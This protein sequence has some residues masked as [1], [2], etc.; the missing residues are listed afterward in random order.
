MRPRPNPAAPGQ[1]NVWYYPRPAVAEQSFRHVRI[2]HHDVVV[3]DTRSAFR[4]FETCHTTSWYL[5]LDGIASGLLRP[6][7]RRS[8]CE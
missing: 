4:V 2:E 6:S 3:A 1:E 8:F 7:S 5:P